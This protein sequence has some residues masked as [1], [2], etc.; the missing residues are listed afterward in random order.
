MDKSKKQSGFSPILVILI[1]A[2]V[3]IAVIVGWRVWDANQNIQPAQTQNNTQ[4]N[5]PST[6]FVLQVKELGIKITLPNSL[7]DIE[8]VINSS[9]KTD[10]GKTIIRADFSTKKIAGLDPE[11]SANGSAPPLGSLV[12]V[13]GAYPSNPNQT[14]SG[15]QLV[16]QF[17]DFYI[18]RNSPQAACAASDSP[19]DKAGSL[20][21]GE[22]F[23]ALTLI[24]LE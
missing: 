19:A 18:A 17:T 12:K 3:I 6:T 22:F 23:P 1:V 2:A 16:K 4:T 7:S 21:R 11:C 10:D 20:A 9:S 14:N 15:G 24:D 13:A 8:Y 5:P